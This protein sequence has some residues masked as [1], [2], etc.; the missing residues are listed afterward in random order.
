MSVRLFGS[1]ENVSLVKIDTWELTG[2]Q[3]YMVRHYKLYAFVMTS[4]YDTRQAIRQR[5]TIHAKQA[6]IEPTPLGL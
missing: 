4:H 5:F 1:D 2:T 3:W 6:E